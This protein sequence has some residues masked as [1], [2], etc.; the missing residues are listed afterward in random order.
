MKLELSNTKTEVI[1]RHGDAH[2]TWNVAS[3][4]KKQKSRADPETEIEDPNIFA[5]INGYWATLAPETQNTIF[6]VYERIQD[7]FSKFWELDTLTYGLY[8]LVQELMALHNLD[9]INHWVKFYSGIVYPL[10]LKE[11]FVDSHDTGQTR[12]R[13]YLKSDYQWLVTMSIALRPMMPVWGLFISRT[14]KET[15]TQFKEYRAA[16]LLSRS[17]IFRSIPM[18]KLRTYLSETVSGDKA[19]IGAVYNGLST[20]DLPEWMLGLTL[21]RRLSIASLSGHSGQPSIIAYIHNYINHRVGRDGGFGGDVIRK[22]IPDRERQ[23]SEQ[24]LSTIENYKIKKENPAGDAISISHC[25]RGQKELMC[26]LA[27]DADSKLLTLSNQSVRGLIDQEIRE[28]QI[29]L[30][31]NVIQPLI[32]HEG[33]AEQIKEDVLSSLAVAQAVLWHRGYKEL[34]GLMTATVAPDREEFEVSMI[35]SRARIPKELLDTLNKLFP[36][37]RRAARQKT[38]RQSNVAANNID[39]LTEMFSEHAWRLTLPE[40]WV[41]QLTGDKNDRR[42]LVPHNMKI[43]LAEFTVD[44]VKRSVL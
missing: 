11:E 12:S 38:A 20:T 8:P 30:M 34:A 31:K 23:D 27:P 28:A 41:V 15:G 14:K 1:L 43:L 24:N 29:L 21:V 33:I 16:R 9:H 25:L 10:D 13:T 40:E 19:R 2:L 6:G 32:P 3:L 5:E 39:L 4:S 42:Y 26:R 18:E 36:F 35:E 7:V 44:N 17:E 37:A 22:K